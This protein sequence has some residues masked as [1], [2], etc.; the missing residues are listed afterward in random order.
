MNTHQGSRL[1]PTCAKFCAV[2]ALLT[3]YSPILARAQITTTSVYRRITATASASPTVDLESTNTGLFANSVDNSSAIGD[4]SV[5]TRALVDSNV[6][7]TDTSMLVTANAQAETS[8]VSGSIPAGP[9]GQANVFVTVDFI[10]HTPVSYSINAI[11]S[12][13]FQLQKGTV[14]WAT[15]LGRLDGG[16]IYQFTFLANTSFARSF[17]V[18]FAKGVLPPGAY[19]VSCGAS[20]D[21]GLLGGTTGPP[22]SFTEFG[23]FD[24]FE[25]RATTL[26]VATQAPVINISLT[27]TN[28]VISWPFSAIGFKLEEALTLGGVVDWHWNTNSPVLLEEQLAVFLPNRNGMRFFRL[29]WDL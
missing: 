15:S 5:G 10:A 3:T 8:A 20:A 12:F 17:G 14:R 4:S 28:T 22:K 11:R 25:F 6:Q 16:S 21:S 27:P 13:D 18:E 9:S 24:G 2:V 19:K 23:R 1:H 7:L 29:K 26:P